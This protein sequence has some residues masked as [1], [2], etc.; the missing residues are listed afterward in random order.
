MAITVKELGDW[1]VKLKD[2]D[3]IGIDSTNTTLGVVDD[4]KNTKIKIRKKEPNPESF[5]SHRSF[6]QIVK[7]NYR[8]IKI[9]GMEKP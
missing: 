1:L 4:W 9:G 6:V 5:P 7:R 3:F 8:H 2:E